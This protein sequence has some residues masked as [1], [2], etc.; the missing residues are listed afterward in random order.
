M[1]GATKSLTVLM[2]A[3]DQIIDAVPFLGQRNGDGISF[4]AFLLF[5]N[6][7]QKFSS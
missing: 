5:H 1:T 6:A 3:L 4:S 7:K 2:Y